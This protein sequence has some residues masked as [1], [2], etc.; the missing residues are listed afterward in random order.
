MVWSI[1]LDDFKS[2]CSE[3]PYPLTRLVLSNLKLMDRKKCMPLAKVNDREIDAYLSKV[4]KWVPSS[5]EISEESKEIPRAG[6]WN[7][8]V[9]Y[10][11]NEMSHAPMTPPSTQLSIVT[12]TKPTTVTY[13]K[14][15]KFIYYQQPTTFRATPSTTQSTT[16]LS[17][18]YIHTRPTSTTSTPF[19]NRPLMTVTKSPI[20]DIDYKPEKLNELIQKFLKSSNANVNAKNELILEKIFKQFFN[21]TSSSSANNDDRSYKFLSENFKYMSNTEKYFALTKPPVNLMPIVKNLKDS[22]GQSFDNLGCER[23]EDGE[24]VRDPYDC[25]AFFTCFMGRASKKSKCEQGLAFDNR[26]KVCNWKSQVIC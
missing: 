8:N 10:G 7:P 16:A 11:L 14:T 24:F 25:G 5:N 6:N 23:L 17:L 26:L 13:M 18:S 21:V 20:Y 9:Q 19:T 22:N 12:Q 4:Y 3:K 15:S 2:F 1:D